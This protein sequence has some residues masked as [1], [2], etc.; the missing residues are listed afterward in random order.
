MNTYFTSAEPAGGLDF[1]DIGT[2]TDCVQ[3]TNGSGSFNEGSA[4][5]NLGVDNERNFG[6]GLNFMATG[7]EERWNRGSSKSRSSC[8]SPV[9]NR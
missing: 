1:A 9:I 7:Q 8:E 3:E 4:G 6:N 5:E 2:S